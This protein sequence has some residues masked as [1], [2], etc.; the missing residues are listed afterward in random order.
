MF[1]I[2]LI[3]H[4]QA[5]APGFNERVLVSSPFV[6][7]QTNQMGQPLVHPQTRQP[8]IMPDIAQTIQSLQQQGFLMP[9]LTQQHIMVKVL[10]YD[11][12]Q[13]PITV[14]M[15][16]RTPHPTVQQQA[17]VNAPFNMPVGNP[18]A[19]N[20]VL[21]IGSHGGYDA[22]PNSALPSSADPL[23]GVQ[24]SYGGAYQHL[25][26]NKGR[27]TIRESADMTG[28]ARLSDTQQAAID[29]RNAAIAAGWVPPPGQ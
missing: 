24:D 25:D 29:R 20:E 27:D 4:P 7:Q 11:P 19:P 23:F 9:N 3:V 13:T 2:C 8:L 17:P 12:Q 18:G 15:V 28:V 6:R 21:P 26:V 5:C 22:M 14:L 16:Q 1:H 10:G